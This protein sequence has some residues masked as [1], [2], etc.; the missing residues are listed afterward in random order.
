M[1]EERDEEKRPSIVDI[2]ALDIYPILGFFI[3]ILGS[4]TWQ[5]IGLQVDPRTQ[6]IEKDF[7]KATL[8]IDCMAYLIDKLAPKLE[9]VE[10]E[11][12]QA[13][14]TDLQIN[15]VRQSETAKE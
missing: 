10:R 12:L 5:Y 3:S 9:D 11:K 2:S 1:S 7:D 14:L 8:T 13:L 6:K 4:K 15:Y